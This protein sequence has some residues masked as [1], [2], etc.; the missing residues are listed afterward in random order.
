MCARRSAV[1]ASGRLSPRTVGLPCC[2]RCSWLVTSRREGTRGMVDEQLKLSMQADLNPERPCSQA[3]LP[4][5]LLK[6]AS[7]DLH[8]ADERGCAYT[9]LL[10]ARPKLRT[11]SDARLRTEKP[12]HEARLTGNPLP[13][14]ARERGHGIDV[15]G[16]NAPVHYRLCFCAS[17]HIGDIGAA[18]RQCSANNHSK[19]QTHVTFP[20]S[21]PSAW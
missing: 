20:M 12:I 16:D 3:S 11:P 1:R 8:I 9:R 13:T 17:H 10:P 15:F 21:S 14:C 2:C 18:H 19:N 6:A 5:K 4:G 7:P